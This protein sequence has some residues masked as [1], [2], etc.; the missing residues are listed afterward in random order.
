MKYFHF[1]VLLLLLF[2][3]IAHAQTTSSING[4]VFA[5]YYYNLQ[6]NDSGEKDRNAFQFRRIYFTFTFRIKN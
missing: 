3:I 4:L 1:I 5:D 2:A 6:N